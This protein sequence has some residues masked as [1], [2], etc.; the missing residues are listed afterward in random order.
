M[1]SFSNP[2]NSISMTTKIK[3]DERVQ[4][5]MVTPDYLHFLLRDGRFLMVPLDWFPRLHAATPEQRSRWELTGAGF[6]VRWPDL[7][8]DLEITGLLAGNAAPERRASIDVDAAQIREYR[9]RASISQS[10]LAEEL[11]VRQATI[12]DWEKGKSSPSPLAAIRLSQSLRKL[13]L[14]AD[15]VEEGA[16]QGSQDWHLSIVSGICLGSYPAQGPTYRF[17]D[18]CRRLGE[19][20]PADTIVL[21]DCKFTD[22]K[23]QAHV[24]VVGPVSHHRFNPTVY[25]G[26]SWASVRR[27]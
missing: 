23:Q 25:F 2:G 13:Q 8:E 21:G 17:M 11:G 19:G 4:H 6:V 5:V 20:S 10:E 1:T 18:L 14:V 22:L 12:S 16:T 9:Q 26:E 27:S 15:G 24:D 7:D 3:P